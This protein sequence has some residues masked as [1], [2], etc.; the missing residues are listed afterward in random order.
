MGAG[1]TNRTTGDGLWQS[2]ERP[3][4]GDERPREAVH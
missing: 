1:E 3:E 2:Q 4:Q